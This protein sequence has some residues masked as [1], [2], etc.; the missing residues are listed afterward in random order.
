MQKYKSIF[1]DNKFVKHIRYQIYQWQTIID[2][3]T[4]SRYNDMNR[5]SLRC[6]NINIARDT[7]DPKIESVTW[8]FSKIIV[9]I[10]W[11]K[12]RFYHHM[13]NLQVENVATIWSLIHC[14]QIL[15]SASCATSMGLATSW[16]N[17][18]DCKF[19]H[20]EVPL[21]SVANWATTWNNLN[22]F[23]I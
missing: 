5:T 9:G 15:W 3:K 19:G 22:W 1:V 17:L 13:P 12:S 7:A 10:V 11:T 14:L 16:S 20:Q 18:T 8:V 2:E 21:A 4:N 23:K 6:F